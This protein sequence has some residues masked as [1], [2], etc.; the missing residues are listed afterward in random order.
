MPF[1][2][3]TIFSIY[4]S[5]EPAAAIKKGHWVFFALNFNFAERDLSGSKNG[6]ALVKEPTS[7]NFLRSGASFS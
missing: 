3:L 1:E 2:F 5:I 7:I 6:D 4:V